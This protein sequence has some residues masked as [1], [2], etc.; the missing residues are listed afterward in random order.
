MDG[1]TIAEFEKDL[2]DNLFKIWNRMSSGSYFPP[3][4]PAV[5]IE[6]AHGAAPAGTTHRASLVPVP[7]RAGRGM[8][9]GSAAAR[10]ARSLESTVRYPWRDE[11]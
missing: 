6:K 1:Q 5:E 8:D 7:G 4:V 2:K 11:A 3:P 10:P 9:G